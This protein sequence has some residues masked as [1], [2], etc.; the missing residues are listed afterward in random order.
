MTA[1][2]SLAR[3]GEITCQVWELAL[4]ARRLDGAGPLPP[5]VAWLLSA[6]ALSAPGP[7]SRCPRVL[8]A[9]PGDARAAVLAQASRPPVTVLAVPGP[10]RAAWAR[11]DVSAFG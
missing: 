10:A 2:P 3:M 5:D 8:A 1:V 11:V 6:V 9:L 7:A 4:R